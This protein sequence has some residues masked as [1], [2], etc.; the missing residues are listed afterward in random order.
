[1]YRACCATLLNGRRWTRTAAFRQR[2]GAPRGAVPV[3]PVGG[4]EG[5]PGQRR[6]RPRVKARQQHGKNAG[7]EYAVKSP[8]AADRSDGRAE[9]AHL[10]EIG[11]IGTDQRTE[12]ARDIG[13]RRRVL[14][15]RV[16]RRRSR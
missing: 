13:E 11:K 6:A 5:L 15:A 7:Q 8:G 14:G 4:F 9:A 16:S 2:P 10:V 3:L 1:M 12:A